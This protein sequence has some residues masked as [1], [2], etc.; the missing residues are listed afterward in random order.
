MLNCEDEYHLSVTKS[1]RRH[2]FEECREVL[3]HELLSHLG[4]LGGSRHE[5]EKAKARETMGGGR[6]QRTIE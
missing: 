1:V 3:G 2:S 5:G 6:L 4:V